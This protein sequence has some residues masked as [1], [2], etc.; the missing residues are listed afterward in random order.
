M[1]TRFNER[2]IDRFLN[3]GLFATIDWDKH[4]HKYSKAVINDLLNG[5]TIDGKRQLT[6]DDFDKQKLQSILANI[7]HTTSKDFDDAYNKR[8]RHSIWSSITKTPYSGHDGN[9]K[10]DGGEVAV[11]IVVDCLWYHGGID[12]LENYKRSKHLKVG[13]QSTIDSALALINQ[14][15]DWKQAAID[16]GTAIA[17]KLKQYKGYNIEHQT[18]MY[19]EIRS[20]GAKLS[21]LKADKWNPGDI[22]LVKPNATIDRSKTDNIIDFNNWVSSNT[23][24]VMISLKKG[25]QQATHGSISLNHVADLPGLSAL[26]SAIHTTKYT[27]NEQSYK[28]IQQLLGKLTKLPISDMIYQYQQDQLIKQITVE[29]NTVNFAT[30]MINGLQFLLNAGNDRDDFTN[31]IE[32]IYRA[33]S[34]RSVDSCNHYKVAGSQLTWVNNKDTL[35][36]T[37][38]RVLVPVGGNSRIVF[39]ITVNGSDQQ[40]VFRSKDYKSSPQFMILHIKG[41][42]PQAKKLSV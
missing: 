6:I 39:D 7:D 18:K 31:I 17:T 22:A 32:A 29:P 26:S 33:A 42:Y 13:D 21:K 12:A 4:D 20:I 34:S 10:N 36:L 40:L 3:E 16:S 8:S 23:D 11:A 28:K 38:N 19:K 35:D 5:K 24:V 1:S 25:D 14:S 9:K 37:V 2:L 30:V 41:Q 27:N 15:H